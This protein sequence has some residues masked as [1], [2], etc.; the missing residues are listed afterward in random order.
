MA[1]NPKKT[2]WKI[3]ED[4]KDGE[5]ELEDLK[6]HTPS[7]LGSVTVLALL[8]FTL[9]IHGCIERRRPVKDPG[10]SQNPIG[11]HRFP[12]PIHPHACEVGKPST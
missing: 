2:P 11:A 12:I 4:G 6:V 10:K 3:L 8:I 7:P 9:G 1:S 5:V